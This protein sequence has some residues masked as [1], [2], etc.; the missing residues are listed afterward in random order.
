MIHYYGMCYYEYSKPWYYA[1]V[2]H[3]L[4]YR[5]LWLLYVT[6]HACVGV[7]SLNRKNLSHRRG[8]IP[9]NELLTESK[10]IIVFG[11]DFLYNRD[12]YV[13]RKCLAF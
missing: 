1:K 6:F 12:R 7:R 9:M 2:N 13:N 3:F 11:C 10:T 5:E 8:N 4:Q